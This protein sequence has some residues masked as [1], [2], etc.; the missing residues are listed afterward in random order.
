MMT[1]VRSAPSGARWIPWVF[2]GGMGLVF[3][4]NA[5]MVWLAFASWS[6]LST[7]APYQRGLAYNRVLDAVARQEALGWQLSAAFVPE[8]AG[9]RE[10]TIAIAV[11]DRD[12][13]PVADLALEAEAARPLAEASSIALDLR[14]AGPGRYAAAA[15]LPLAGQW[16]LRLIARRAGDSLQATRRFLVP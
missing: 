12:G 13:R 16:E 4:V 7:T 3:A 8:H 6:G 1:T 14:P 11:S 5:V 2:V 9:A 10:G 15:A